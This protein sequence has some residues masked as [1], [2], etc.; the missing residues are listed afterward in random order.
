MQNVRDLCQPHESIFS[1]SKAET[2]ANIGDVAIPG[3]IKPEEFFAGNY[4]TTGMKSLLE[5]VFDRL[6][7]ASQQGVFRLKEAMGGGKTHNLIAACLLAQNP[8]ARKKFF[9]E[10]GRNVSGVPVRVAVFDGRNTDC[11]H[12]VWIELLRQLDRQ[13]KA[14]GSKDDIPGPDTWAEWIGKDPCLIVLDELPPYLESLAMKKVNFDQSEADRLTQALANLMTAIAR[15]LLP[16][17]CLILSDLVSAWEK[18]SAKINAAIETACK[19]LKDETARV[20]FDILPVRL[21]NAELYGILRKRLFAK[22]P[23]PEAVQ[24]VAEAYHKAYST[25]VQQRAIPES[26]TKWAG[27]I[28]ETYPFHPGLDDLIAR[29]REN[30]GFQ[31]TREVLRLTQKMTAQVWDRQRDVQLIHPHEL[32]FN[33]AELETMLDTIHAGLA[34]ARSHDIVQRGSGAAE[35]LAKRM[36]NEAPLDAAKLVYFSSLSTATNALQGLTAEE[37]AAYLCAPD[38]DVAQFG[39][40]LLTA[41]EDESWYLHRRTDDRW[42]YREVK[43]VNSRIKQDA[44]VMTEDLRRKQVKEHLEKQFKPGQASNGTKPAY[45]RSLVFPAIDDIKLDST[46]VT[47]VISEPSPLNES[48]EDGLH[49]DLRHF[50]HQEPWK[51]RVLFLTG[52]DGFAAAKENA[53]YVKAADDLIAEFRSEGRDDRGPEVKQAKDAFERASKNLRSAL[54]ECF[55]KLLFPS[56]DGLTPA[57]LKFE[58]AANKYVGEETI[59]DSLRDEQKFRADAKQESFR[60]EFEEVIF[61]QQTMP[62]KDILSTMGRRPDWY[63]T[64]PGAIE[65]LK[66][67]CLLK[68]IWRDEDNGYVRKGPFPKEKATVKISLISRDDKTGKAVLNV[69]ARH[70]DRV[71]YQAGSAGVTSASPMVEG[72]RLETSEMAIS[73]LAIDSTGQHE[74]GA[75]SAWKNTIQLRYKISSRD[76]ANVLELESAPPAGMRFTFDGSDPKYGQAYSGP[77]AIPADA[78]LIQAIAERDD[79]WSNKTEVK[80]PPPGKKVIIDK[81]D[82]IDPTKPATWN[83]RLKRNDRRSSFEAIAL[84][85]K[86]NAHIL[87][88]NWQFNTD[89]DHD[90]WLEVSAGGR[91]KFGPEEL[92]ALVSGTDAQLPASD[93][94]Q[95]LDAS[96]KLGRLE[97]TTGEQLLQLAKALGEEVRKEEVVQK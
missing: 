3:R 10:L 32:D 62:W 50:W 93:D 16:N 15:N 80:P 4:V 40:G 29:F 44:S 63:W 18:G 64:P 47:L 13:Q 35:D 38:R 53:A 68:G 23:D 51:N 89:E 77:V 88:F 78:A 6:L 8:A 81:D 57:S 33:D 27:R 85:K 92:E 20:C 67:Q 79:I 21:D 1:K 61:A 95:R 97:F 5:Q 86:Y 76:G 42:H 96:L 9:S 48:R 12:H 83:R 82:D 72:G 45:Q 66:Q 56:E 49:P 94:T 30:P 41:L 91:M 11:K 87:G 73:F 36:G 58:F 59:L 55:T 34:N 52:T 37:V 19:N 31:Q 43:N 84:L 46:E 65:T 71:H 69:E 26:Y 14:A 25:A 74:S 22:L 70:G 17:C 60:Q 28:A 75:P 54:R 39:P 90:R 24:L 2:V 7:E